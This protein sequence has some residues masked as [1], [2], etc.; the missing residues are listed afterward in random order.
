MGRTRI[1]AMA[2]AGSLVLTGCGIGHSA[3]AGPA[4]TRSFAVGGF[5]KLEVAG[6]YQ[7]RITT[8]GAPMVSARG[9]QHAL[10]KMVVEVKGDTLEIHPEKGGWLGGNWTMFGGYRGEKVAVEVRV[11]MVESV[12]IAGSGD[13]SVDR[14]T[15]TK[16]KGEIAGSGR[17][18]LPAV[19]VGELGLEIAGSGNFKAVGKATNVR[20]EIAGSGDIDAGGVQAQNASAEITGSGN[21]AAHASGTARLEITGS[22]DINLTGGAKCQNEKTGSGT[23]RCS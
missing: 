14:I 11:P 12:A 2:T 16:F 10:D 15:G 7:V 4:G 9:G 1:L 5:T 18:D 19:D 13:V 21:I 22:G 20:Y 3:N 8:G 6:P 17:L 23:I